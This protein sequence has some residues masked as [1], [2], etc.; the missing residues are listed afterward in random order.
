MEEVDKEISEMKLSLNARARVVAESYLLAVRL[1][2]KII[3]II[4]L[5]WLCSS[6][7]DVLRWIRTPFAHAQIRK[8]NT[9]V[10]IMYCILESNKAAITLHLLSM[11]LITC[12]GPSVTHSFPCGADAP[13]L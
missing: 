4:S 10:I 6:P 11:A 2:S 13:F 1:F 9:T 8:G 5:I 12:G 7:H 3:L